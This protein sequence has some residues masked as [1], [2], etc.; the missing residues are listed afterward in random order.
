[1]AA[2]HSIILRDAFC[3]WEVELWRERRKEEGKGEREGKGK[4]LKGN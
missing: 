3:I 4:K 1:M 2:E